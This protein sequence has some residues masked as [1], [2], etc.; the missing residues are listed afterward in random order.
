MTYTRFFTH[1]NG[2]QTLQGNSNDDF[3]FF[4]VSGCVASTHFVTVITEL[5]FVEARA[6]IDQPALKSN[7][8]IIR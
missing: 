8:F 4:Y 7:E 5:Q 6:V 3:L 2:N 1:F